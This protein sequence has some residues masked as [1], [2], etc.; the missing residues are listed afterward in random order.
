MSK[1]VICGATG[2]L[3]RLITSDIA[4]QVAPADITLTT[5]SPEKLAAEAEAGMHVVYADYR[6]RASLD[7]AFAGCDTLMLISGLNLLKRVEEHRNAIEAAE[8]AGI[9]HIVYTSVSGVHPMNRTPSSTEHYATEQMLQKSDLSFTALRNQCYSE[10]ASEMAMIPLLTGVW[11]HIG[12]G[13]YSPVARA[14]IAACAAAIL[15]E[16]QNHRN[17]SYEITGPELISFRELSERFAA[18]YDRPI[19]F[20]TLT[21]DQMWARF[22]EWGVP[23]IGDPSAPSPHCFGSNELVENYIAW[24]QLYHAVVSRHVEFITGRA[25]KPLHET[26][27][28]AKPA[29]LQQLAVMAAG[30]PPA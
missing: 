11:D 25:P 3:G 28:E 7:A 27:L 15:L 26:M 24:D 19:E 2:Q 1:S 14:D 22:D 20:V 10:Y 30:G 21:P 9:T 4:K 18:M 23:R 16:P 29:V 8:Q 6:D 12:T 5:R 13:L 17:V